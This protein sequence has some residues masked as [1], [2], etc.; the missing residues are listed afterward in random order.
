MNYINKIHEYFN[1]YKYN[2]TLILY[3]QQNFKDYNLVL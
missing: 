1:Y 2:V 3:Q